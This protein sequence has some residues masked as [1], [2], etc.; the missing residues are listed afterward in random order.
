MRE[1][2]ILMPISALPS[3]FGIGCFSKEA[4]EFVDQIKEAGLRLW[5]VLPLGPTG[6]GD[7]PYQSFSSFAGNPYFINLE[8]LM[9]YG[10]LTEEECSSVDFGEDSEKVNYGKLYQVRF[11]LLRKAHLRA[12]ERG[13]LN[14]AGFWEFCRRE[15]NWL[16]DYALFMALKDYFQGASWDVWPRELRMREEKALEEYRALLEGEILFQK[17]MQYWFATQWENL[18]AYANG[19]GIE[20]VGDI[21]IYVAFDSADAWTG[22]KLFQFDEE[23]LPVDV[24]GCPPDAFS[25]DGQ[26]WGNPLY[27]WN[28]HEK[29]DFQ[30]WVERMK[31]CFTLYDVVKIDHFRGFE[32]YYAIPYGATTARVGQW[33]PGPGMKLFSAIRKA[34]GEVKIITE[35]LGFLTPAV[36]ALLKESGFPGMKVLQ[37]AFDSDDGTNVYLPHHYTPNCV[38]YTGT[39]DN[40]TML[41]WHKKASDSERKIALDYMQETATEEEA[42]V[43]SYIALAMRSVADRCII[44]MQ[45]FLCLDGWAR[46][47][48]PSILG[49]NWE[50][51]MLPG[52][53]TREIRKRIL[54][55][56]KLTGR[57]S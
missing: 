29:T 36:R 46:F 10:L 31:H 35:D 57:I 26:L 50:W 56:T 14:Q 28:Y 44:P 27:D 25:E 24:A 48:T 20:I 42:I 33:M 22:P 8:A 53:F 23:N 3:R 13:D 43:W 32:S 1:S 49:G 18:K 41:G 54:S 51:R 9:G 19:R 30:W 47:N 38:V 2:G 37:F 7:S 12:K 5:Q 39:H 45:D 16:D 52:A 15:E 40:D 4:Y 6:F 34:L 21:P 17:H 55:M 11:T